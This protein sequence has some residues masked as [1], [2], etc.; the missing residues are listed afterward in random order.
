MATIATNVIDLDNF[1]EN[2][3]AE[4]ESKSDR[5]F[6]RFE[7]NIEKSKSIAQSLDRNGTELHLFHTPIGPLALSEDS[8]SAFNRSILKEADTPLNAN[9]SRNEIPAF[10]VNQLERL[11][12]FVN[13]VCRYKPTSVKSCIRNPNGEDAT[14]SFSS[15]EREF[16]VQRTS[17]NNG[18]QVLQLSELN[19]PANFDYTRE[20]NIQRFNDSSY[21]ISGFSTGALL[22]TYALHRSDKA[23]QLV[24]QQG[25]HN[26]VLA[27]K[28]I[29]QE[30]DNAQ[31][32]VYASWDGKELSR[33]KPVIK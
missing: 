30:Y 26:R 25:Y 1:I 22:E 14:I 33:V 19:N 7:R 9:V 28:L 29:L 3:R 21:H 6:V 18:K 8:T 16:L 27:A 4:A 11:W 23:P 15:G 5:D 2:I 20:L 10:M 31:A 17:L 24:F 32:H 12:G 13:L